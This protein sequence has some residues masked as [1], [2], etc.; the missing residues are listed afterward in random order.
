MKRAFVAISVFFVSAVLVACAN[1]P[2]RNPVPPELTSQ[3]GIEGVPEARF[4]ADEWPRFSLDRF[5]THSEEDFQKHYSG[6]FRKPHSY[7]AISGGGARG[8]FGAASLRVGL[9]VGP[10]RSLSW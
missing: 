4:W 10:G 1:T 9:I 5:E 3:V 6:I 2:A 7:L 8:A